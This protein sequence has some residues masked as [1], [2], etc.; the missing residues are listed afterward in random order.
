MGK[1]SLSGSGMNIPD[2]IRELIET[3]RD[4]GWKNSDLGSGIRDKHPR[5]A[6]KSIEEKCIRSLALE[7]KKAL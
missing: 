5:S 7:G 3:I 6:T 2:H 1:K 4:P